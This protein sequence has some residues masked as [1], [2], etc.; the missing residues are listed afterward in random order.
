MSRRR[1]ATEPP[2]WSAATL[3]TRSGD[4]AG[5]TRAGTV[6]LAAGARAE[7]AWTWTVDKVTTGRGAGITTTACSEP[8]CAAAACATGCWKAAARAT[9]R[10]TTPTYTKR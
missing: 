9:P 4:T 1:V 2:R 3:L 8:G 7:S 10:L 6:G 5:A